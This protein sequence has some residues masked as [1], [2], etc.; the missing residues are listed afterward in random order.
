MQDFRGV[1]QRTKAVI[2]VAQA[3]PELAALDF[4]ECVDNGVSFIPDQCRG[5]IAFL[6]VWCLVRFSIC[7]FSLSQFC[8]LN[9]LEYF[10]KKIQVELSRSGVRKR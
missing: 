1:I 2:L 4:Q 7:I 3:M 8:I 9:L 10:V 5:T 6:R